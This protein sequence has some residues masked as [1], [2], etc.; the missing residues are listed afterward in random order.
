MCRSELGEGPATVSPQRI[1]AGHPLRVHRLGLDHGVLAAEPLDLNHEVQRVVVPI[2]DADDEVRPVVPLRAAHAVRH[3]ETHAVVLGVCQHMRVRFG[4]AAELGFPVAVVHHPVHVALGRW[5]LRSPQSLLGSGEVHLPCAACG[6]EGV[7]HDAHGV[8][9]GQRGADGGMDTL[10]GHVGDFLMHHLR[11]PGAAAALEV[12]PHPFLCDAL[13]LAEQVQLRVLARIAVLAI[14]QVLGQVEGDRVVARVFQVLHGQVHALPHDAQVLCRGRAHQVGREG[15]AGVRTEGRLQALGRQFHPIAIDSREADLQRIALGADGL[16][17]RGL[18]RR[19]GR[20]DDRLGREVEGYAQHV[21]VFHVELVFGV[22]RVALAAQRAAHH[23]L[24]QQLRTECSHAQHV[25]HRVGIPA[26]GEHGHADDAADALA[27]PARLAHGVH[28][29]AQQVGVSQFVSRGAVAGAFHDFAAKALDRVGLDVAEA[30]VQRL[31]GFQLLAVDQQ[32]TW[33]RQLLAVVV[34]VAEQLEATVLEGGGAA[35]LARVQVLALEARDVVIDQLRCRRVVAHHDEHRRHLDALG[36]PAVE[37][38]GVVAVQGLQRGVQLGRQGQRVQLA[39]GAHALLRH[40]LADVV[41]QVAEL[42]RVGAGDV[43]RHRHA[44][45]LDDAAFDGVHQREV[46]HRP[47]EQRAFGI[48]RA[49]QEERRGRQVEHRRHAELALHGFDATDPQPGGFVVLL[50]LVLVVT[51]EV[52]EVGLGLLRLGPVAVVGFV[53]DDEHVLDAHE[54]G[55][56]TLQHLAFGL[57]GLNRCAS[58]LEQRPASGSDVQGL[59]QLEGVIV[60][61]HDDGALDVAEHVAGHDLAAGVV[62]VR[63]LW[64]QHAQTVLDGQ[65]WCHYEEAARELLAGRVAHR[66]HGLP[67]DEHGHDGGLAGARGQFQRDAEQ[68]R[69]GHRVCAGQVLSELLS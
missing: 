39:G 53:V 6:I 26:F 19:L 23:L 51:L 11:L 16:H 8:R 36:L 52:F 20:H 37:D 55:H 41:P 24:A 65:A 22:Q 68:V 15:E 29:L 67:C 54:F 2:V 69:V 13:E 40:A 4:H 43:V 58:A 50:R 14:Q 62:A 18:H 63:V 47:R 30:G 60:G 44:R 64:Q 27:Q 59:A 46:A 10:A 28:H 21:G 3:F 35:G 61:D 66:I 1:H 33:P 31:A 5:A 48:A 49:A 38:L 12:V 25:G 32:R 9:A 34:V 17:A 42:R 56:H 57:Q 45:Q 7:Q